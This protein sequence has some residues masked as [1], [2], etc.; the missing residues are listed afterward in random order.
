MIIIN[1]ETYCDI[2]NYLMQ[3]LEKMKK[4]INYLIILINAKNIMK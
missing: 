1:L 2:N 3:E 4:V